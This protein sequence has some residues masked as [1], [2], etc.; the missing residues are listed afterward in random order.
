MSTGSSVVLTPVIPG[1][2]LPLPHALPF[3]FSILFSTFFHE[4]GH[5]ISAA[6]E[7]T[8]VDGVGVALIGYEHETV[9]TSSSD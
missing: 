6:S 4:L 3:L 9:E 1:I 7:F 5:G 2:N 8:D